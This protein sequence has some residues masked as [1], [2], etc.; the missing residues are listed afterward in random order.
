MKEAKTRERILDSAEKLFAKKGLKHT[1]VRDITGAA[2]AHLA[3]VNYHFRSKDGLLREVVER[4]IVPLNRERLRLLDS[5]TKR[6]GKKAVPVESALHALLSPA[7]KLYFE[8]PHFL[9]IA[10]Q[11]A[12]DPDDEVYKIFLLHFQEVFSGFKE[13]FTESLPYI[14]DEE[15]MWRMHFLMGAM[16]HTWTNHTGL[17]RLSGGVC[18]LSDE[19]ETINRLIAFCAAGLRAPTYNNPP[20]DGREVRTKGV[21]STN[22]D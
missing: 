12:S 22:K 11:I 2:K 1:S 20:E 17:E 15:I 8:R 3:A 13:V 7:V 10:G 4:R 19:E 18:R 21:R 9:R 5:A 14:E 16:I 6:F